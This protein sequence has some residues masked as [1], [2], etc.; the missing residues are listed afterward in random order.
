MENTPMNRKRGFT[1]IELLVVMAIIALLIG[2]LLPAL[3]KARAQAKLLKDN[4]Q[5]KQMHT[6]WVVFSRELDGKFPTPGL[7]N[8][9]PDPILGET[10]GRGPENV[11]AND[12]ANMHSVCIMQNYY[13]PDLIVG[14]TEPSG[15]VF[16]F[17]QYDWDLYDVTQDIYWDDRFA[18]DLDSGCNT[19][20]A[21]SPIGGP[22]KAQWS[23]TFDS[24]YAAAGNRGVK[25]GE[26]RAE[27]LTYE[28]HG[29]RKQWV[30]NVCYNDNHVVTED[31]FYPV[32]LDASTAAGGVVPDNL[33]RND[34]GGND[35]LD[36]LD[37]YLV[38]ISAL[39]G[40]GNTIT[41]ELEW[42]D[43]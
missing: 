23:E 4:A 22:R 9:G 20:Y 19:S 39:T 13:T 14:P 35:N 28:I 37:C 24:K 18:V 1:L 31:T 32:G 6:G 8:R 26:I 15:N 36:G 43:F 17:D 11:L 40:G 2:L 29:G 34:Q 3:A 16:I 27:S 33:F 38:L 12:H 5:I 42:D 7:I 10:P 25:W 21:S 41:A 30:G